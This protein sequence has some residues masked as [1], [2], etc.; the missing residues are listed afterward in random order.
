MIGVRFEWDEAKNL[1]NQR[2]HDSVSFEEASQ[3]FRD[4]LHVSV[5]DR[6]EGGEQR[7]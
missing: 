6:I 3:V 4:P 5:Q 2:K 1:S 7:W